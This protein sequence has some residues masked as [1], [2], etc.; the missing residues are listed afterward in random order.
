MILASKQAVDGRRKKAP[1]FFAAACSTLGEWG[2]DM[3]A[4]QKWLVHAY[5]LK[6]EEEGDHD[7]GSSIAK[8]TGTA[9]FRTSETACISPLQVELHVNC[10]RL[11]CLE[12]QTLVFL[13]F[14]L[15]CLFFSFSLY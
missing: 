2:Q 4:F 13:D 11:D 7:D 5:A 15:F 6:L 9:A 14:A 10:W 1:R 3:F 8:L 12:C